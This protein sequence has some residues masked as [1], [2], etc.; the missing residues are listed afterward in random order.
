MV[1]NRVVIIELNNMQNHA[2]RK[3]EQFYEEYKR[4]PNVH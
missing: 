3:I 2:V 1:L 4:Q